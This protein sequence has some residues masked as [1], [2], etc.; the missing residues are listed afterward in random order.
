MIKTI[1]MT[2]LLQNPS[3][4]REFVK[5]G[6]ILLVKF[7]GDVVMQIQTPTPDEVLLKNRKKY[8]IG[9]DKIINRQEIYS[10]NSWLNKGMDGD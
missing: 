8:S 3:K 7:E 9:I 5:S 1:T 4:I 10:D 2:Y 6:N